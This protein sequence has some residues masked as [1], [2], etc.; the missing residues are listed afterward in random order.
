MKFLITK[1]LYNMRVIL[2]SFLRLAILILL[3]TPLKAQISSTRFQ[4]VQDKGY[5]Y[6]SGVTTDGHDYIYYEKV[7]I[8]PNGET[9]TESRNYYFTKFPNGK[10]VCYSWMTIYPVYRTND[11]VL[12]YNSTN[13]LKVGYME[14]KDYENNTLYK[15]KVDTGMCVV[16]ATWNNKK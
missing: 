8:T 12:F 10:E 15:V 9:F 3:V 5:G 11:V 7:V 16:I 4:I 2:F 6:T 13:Y 14:W 1:K